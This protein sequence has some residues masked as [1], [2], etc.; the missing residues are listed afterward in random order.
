MRAGSIA[1]SAAGLLALAG[2]ATAG[3]LARQNAGLEIDP[4]LACRAYGATLGVLATLR[5][6]DALS[7][8][9][10]AAVDRW[11]PVLNDICEGA[12]VD[13]A[14][15]TTTL[16]EAGLATLIAIEKEATP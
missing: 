11:R 12:S 6:G 8:R 9:Q 1:L 16:L 10:I 3:G 2:C 15:D 4:L 14:F 5:A 7:D 13:T